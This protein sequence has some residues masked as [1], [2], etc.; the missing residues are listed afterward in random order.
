MKKSSLKEDTV[1][2]SDLRWVY[3]YNIYP[4]DSKIYSDKVFV[5]IEDGSQGG[6]HWCCFTL[7]GKN[8]STLT[9][10]EANLINLYLIN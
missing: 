2:E 6:T 1:N 9:H 7:K 5:N 4:R 10:L 8:L 3:N